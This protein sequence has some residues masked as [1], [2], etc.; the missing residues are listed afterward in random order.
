LKNV[1]KKLN[2]NS[3]W[4]NAETTASRPWEKAMGR[5]NLNVNRGDNMK[6]LAGGIK[7]N[8]RHNLDRESSEC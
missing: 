6:S 8:I 3:S 2:L 7:S 4:E 1:P 5:K